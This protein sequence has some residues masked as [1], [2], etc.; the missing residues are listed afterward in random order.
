MDHS[1]QAETILVVDNDPI[2]CNLIARILDHQGYAVL[3]ALSGEEALVAAARHAGS[4]PLLVTEILMSGM[5][6]FRLADLLAVSRPEIRALFIC[7]HYGD[8]AGVPQG[9]YHTQRPFLLKPFRQDQLASAIREALDR[10]PDRDRDLFA[11]VLADPKVAAQPMQEGPLPQGLPRALRFQARL[12]TRYRTRG[13]SD[14]HNG[15][16]ENL[17]R[18]G[19]LFRSIYPLE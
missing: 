4:L 9:L 1:T 12:T 19:V 7:G 2:L 13:S 10:P 14:W 3:Q 11:L 5:D 18:S 8:S 15:V 17:S 6:G 16:T